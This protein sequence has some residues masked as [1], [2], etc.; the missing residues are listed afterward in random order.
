MLKTIK[1]NN[2]PIIIGNEALKQVSIF[3]KKNTYS[4]YFILCDEH[5]FQN[6]LPQLLLS[7]KPLKDA[8]IIEIESGESSKSIEIV[9]LCWLTLLENNANKNTLLINLGGGVVSDLGGFIAA[10]YKRGIDFINIP[11]TLLAMADASVGGKTGINL[12]NI[13]NSIGVISQPKA[14]FIYQGF[15]KTLPHKHI[16][17]GF[18]EI[19]KIALVKNKTF[20][21]KISTKII[22]NSFNDVEIINKSIEL[23]NNIVKIDPNENGTRKI[24]NFGHTIGHAVESLFFHKQFSLLHGEAVAIG[25]AIES[26]L[27]LLLKRITT[28]EFDKISLCLKLHFHFPAIE[29]NDQALFF[30]YFKQDKKHKNKY[31]Q[32]SLLNGI[33][34]CDYDVKISQ[35]QLQ[36]AVLYY[37]S[38]IANA[39]KI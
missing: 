17:N 35:T 8:E 37:N 38:K 3:L 21:N 16:I 24:L 7:C 14:V 31:Y 5:T 27:C 36:Q 29:S 4:S 9:N 34:Y 23:K 12:G 11:T 10:T 32:L 2:Y 25:I 1:A 28:N 15:L 18:A 13:K 19:I 30:N 6:C 26:Y 33:G 22:G 20:F 39:S